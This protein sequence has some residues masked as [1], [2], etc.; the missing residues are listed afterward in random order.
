M[1]VSTM[2]FLLK[3]KC[4]GEAEKPREQT[5]P[6]RLEMENLGSLQQFNQETRTVWFF[7]VEGFFFI[8]YER[9]HKMDLVNKARD[10]WAFLV[11]LVLFKKN[12]ERE[13]ILMG[14][15]VF[16]VSLNGYLIFVALWFFFSFWLF[17]SHVLS[18][19]CV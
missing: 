11:T 13:R 17:L 3:K 6:I 15:M 5:K 10:H 1:A 14:F 8:T 19:S 9:N 4:R 2:G 7:V 12:R 16:S 18:R